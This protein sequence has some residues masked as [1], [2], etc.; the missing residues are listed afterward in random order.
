MNSMNL[1]YPSAFILAMAA[2]LAL[3][4]DAGELRVAAGG[5]GATVAVGN[6]F[7]MTIRN[8]GGDALNDVR[9]LS[10]RN[11]PVTCA[12][13]TSG[14]RAFDAR[15]AAGDTVEC[16]GRSLAPRGKP[17]ASVVV[18]ARDMHGKP[19]QT[20]A[21]FVLEPAAA[22]DQ[23][24]IAVLGGGVHIDTNGDGLLDAGEA[25]DYHYTVLNLGNGALSG[26]GVV[27]QSGAVGCPASTLP[28]GGSME[29]TRHYTLSAADA[30]EGFVMNEV[31]ASAT[32]THGGPV[33]AADVVLRMDL[34]GAADIR[35]IKSPFLADDADGSGYASEGDLLT[36]TFALKNSGGL[37]L[38][39]VDLT[40]PDP[41]LIDAPITCA[42]TTLGGQPF[43]GPGSGALAVNDVVL[44]TADH[45]ITAAD[46]A[47]GEARNLA[48]LGGQ[49]SI[50]GP[51]T[52]AAA[53]AVAIPLPAT[54]DV[55]KALV[56]EGG[57]RSG[58][59]EPGETLT[60]AIR[61]DN[62][63]S[64]DALDVG[65]VDPLDPNVA[66][67]S[68][69]HGGVLAGGTVVW[70]GLLVPANGYLDL[71]VVVR[72]VDP[73]PPD[74]HAVANLAHE[75]GGV[76]PDCDAT[77]RP[78]NCV[79]MPTPGVIDLSKALVAE[80]GSTPGLAEPGEQLTYAITLQN[81]GGSDVNGYSVTDPLDPHVTFVSA[82]HGGGHAAGVVTWS[83]LSIPAGGSVVLTVVV[84][85][86]AFLPPE[87]TR[88]ANVA[89]ESA[90]PPVDCDLVPVPDGCAILPAEEAPRLQVTK[91]VNDATVVPGGTAT[92]VV[93][94]RNVGN[95][96]VNN[97]T[98]NDPIPAGI[99]DFSWTCVAG[100][101]AACANASGTGPLAE[102]VP[103]FP[104]GGE[105][106]YTIAAAV[107]DAATGSL[108]NTVLVEPSTVTACM[109][110]A[111]PAPCD[112]TATVTIVPA[113][114][115]APVP[116]DGRLALVLMAL[117]LAFL[118]VRRARLDA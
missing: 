22:P 118:G 30:A 86:A 49:P 7:V 17:L 56:S 88:I 5:H 14:G 74:V 62:A 115:A 61:L 107:S 32:D 39:A 79:I 60:Y 58:I 16:N 23:G 85:V 112:A 46:A 33:H 9:V 34:G 21:R 89:H 2:A 1:K 4:A 108:L 95:V 45:A 6:G 98:V 55:T 57:S 71:A 117:A 43:S 99:D 82:D 52:G 29:C 51:V 8:E 101:G 19:V 77:P 97:L 68:A 10:D 84:E 80:S 105:L 41:S 109:P 110:A 93:T 92:F 27:D 24:I 42:T 20:H 113:T 65:I 67:V 40:E 12:M 70:S 48:E 90:T 111:T 94:V 11:H 35:G 38:S 63:G 104:P 36:Y 72:V 18:V 87:V 83:G 78:G 66:F 91:S 114:A 64:T 31:E 106:T 47:A 28:D 54:V 102:L 50:G 53:S 15:L 25:I 26:V 76:P 96:V 37:P 75:A 69:D 59:A 100:G 13:V 44:C 103:S 116:V 73:L 81:R 3:P